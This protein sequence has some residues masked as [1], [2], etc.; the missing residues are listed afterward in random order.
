MGYAIIGVLVGHIIVFGGLEETLGGHIIGFLSSLIHTSGFLFLSGFGLFYSLHKDSSIKSFYIR[1]FY[2]FLLP[3]LIVAIPYFLVVTVNKGES[4]WYYVRCVTTIEFWLNGNYHGMWYIAVSLLLYLITP[5]VYNFVCSNKALST[6]KFFILLFTLIGI[7]ALLAFYYENWWNL[8]SIG[9]SRTPI[10]VLGMLFAQW[11]NND[12]DR[13]RYLVCSAF[14][15]LIIY[16]ISFFFDV[17]IIQS[18]VEC[19]STSLYIMLFSVLFDLF[20]KSSATKYVN[21]L[22][23]W[24]GCY[25]FELYILHLYIW[26][27]LKGIFVMSPFQYIVCACILSI[28]L[29]V[30]LHKATHKLIEKLS[31]A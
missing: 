14:I 16:G 21:K 7:N 9:L 11:A 25:T 22:L 30:P 27:V 26:F 6:P 12:L 24:F 19:V 2:R 15:L 10:F 3:F 1:R 23:K 28:V 20:S 17:A 13:K 4:V 5:F 31:K 8:V 18:N 29:C